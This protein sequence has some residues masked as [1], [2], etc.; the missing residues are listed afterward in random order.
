MESSPAF[1]DDELVAWW[2]DLHRHAERGWTEFRTSALVADRLEGWGYRVRLGA[3]I[4]RPDARMGLPPPD[5]LEQA[6]RRALEWGVAESRLAPMRGGFSGA[7][8]TL[9]SGRAG[10]TVALR[11]DLDANDGLLESTDTA[12]HP[13]QAGFGSINPGSQHSCGHD[14][15]T[16]IGLAVAR[17]LAERRDEWAGRVVMVFQPAEEGARGAQAMVEAGVVDDADVLLAGHIGVNARTVGQIVPGYRGF[18]ASTKWDATFLGR[19]SHAGYAPHEGHNALLAAATATLNLHALARHGGGETRVNV[20]TLEAGEVR[21]SIP[22]RAFMRLEVRG[23]SDETHDYM[24]EH[25]GDVLRA[26]AE[27]H[28]CRLEQERVGY[29][30][31]TASDDALT[32]RVAEAA[33]QVPG[34]TE[35]G[36]PYDFGAGDD[37]V[38]MMKRVQQ[39][40]GQA[41]YLGLG[42]PVFGGHHTTTFDFDER[43]LVIGAELFLRVA[44][45]CLR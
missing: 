36:G 35:V 24:A 43:V 28:G 18:L 5:E 21:N 30:A 26:S 13:A 16:A 22:A 9:E 44:L 3:D 12:H 40:G 1:R 25:A 8:G 11:F 19:N 32:A 14:G 45:G 42:S 20:G 7:V 2:R 31:T 27:M 10:P 38:L 29:T 37:A 34:V 41:V 23:D 15:H 6:Y 17:A 39:R 33:R 4:L